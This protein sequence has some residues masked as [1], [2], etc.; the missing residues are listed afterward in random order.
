MP[1]AYLIAVATLAVI[2]LPAVTAI[3]NWW[4]IIAVTAIGG[5]MTTIVVD[6][7]MTAAVVGLQILTVLVCK[8]TIQ[9]HTR[10]RR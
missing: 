10:K 3:P 2:S 5:L 8:I 4:L 7:R 6:T 1:T 9:L